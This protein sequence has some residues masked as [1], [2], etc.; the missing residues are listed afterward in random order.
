M[1][2]VKAIRIY[3][4]VL[5][6]VSEAVLQGD[7]ATVSSYLSKPFHMR[8]VNGWF[9]LNTEE[10]IEQMVRSTHLSLKVQGATDYVRIA[11]SAEFREDGSIEGV[12]ISHILRNGTPLVPSYE[13]RMRMK[14]IGDDWMVTMAK[15]AMD[16]FKWPIMLPDVD[17]G[18]LD[19]VDTIA[20]IDGIAMKTYQDYLDKITAINVAQ[21]FDDWLEACEFPHMVQI[22]RVNRLIETPDDIRQFFNMISGLL[23][24]NPTAKFERKTDFAGFLDS[25]T[26]RGYHTAT[27]QGPDGEVF[28]PV[29]SR[30]TIR[31][32]DRQWRMIEVVN[33]IANTEFPYAK[34]IVSEHLASEFH[35]PKKVK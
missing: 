35:H 17:K 15:H 11:R 27:L 1:S 3:Q 34:P 2:A 9:P 13:N 29:R 20:E 10:D 12:H 33:S 32:K 19:A 26:I 21:D 8:T 23:T 6:S 5:D 30:M 18:D 25:H 28:P 16:N 4:R 7:H 24:E 14:M 22:D 31:F